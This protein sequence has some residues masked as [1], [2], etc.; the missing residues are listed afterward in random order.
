VQVEEAL[1]A[2]RGSAPAPTRHLRKHAA[3]AAAAE[4][5]AAASADGAAPGDA[6]A[7]SAAATPVRRAPPAG[8][9][10]DMWDLMEPEEILTKLGKREGDKPPFAKGAA[11]EKWK[12]R[13]AAFSD[14]R[15]AAGAL[16]L[17]PGGYAEAVGL[18]RRTV[19][20]DANIA[21]VGEAIDAATALA[22]GLRRDFRN[23]AKLLLPCFLDKLKD[24]TTNCIRAIHD[25]LNAFAA[26]CFS[27]L[28]VV[29]DVITVA[30][31]HKVAKV[32]IESMAWVTDCLRHLGKPSATRLHGSL[33]PVL[34]KLT[35]ASAP[36]VRDA[37]L[38]ALAALCA[39]SGGMSIGTIE[40]ATAG[41]EAARLKK[42]NE[43]VGKAGPTACLEADEPSRPQ[44]APPPESPGGAGGKARAGS[45]G[46]A[47]V[48]P[49]TPVGAA[50]AVAA[51]KP[52][53]AAAPAR[54][55][56]AAP[57]RAAYGAAAPVRA[58][59]A[60]A[61]PGVA[62]ARAAAAPTRA[63]PPAVAAPRLAATSRAAP[64]SASAAAAA[65]SRTAAYGAPSKLAATGPPA[66]ATGPR[67]GSGSRAPASANALRR[68]PGAPLASSA[69][70]TGSA[71]AP[72]AAA[73]A[74]ARAGSADGT[75]F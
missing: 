54:P 26:H 3:A 28:E 42:L 74:A 51:R 63:A 4:A 72:G 18:I 17:A 15:T 61:R 43:L 14:L 30:L 56:A 68:A 23:E 52:V 62:P 58:A 10:G 20:A 59:P 35:D 21:V 19:M 8:G 22:K 39:A 45:A 44:Y 75:R 36:A 65:T 73:A 9:A 40:K 32:Q 2:V 64:P 12:E 41:M 5:A 60:P 47:G 1:E 29:D 69:P 27:F 71:G 11:S 6:S 66:A 37:A 70:R 67:P 55:A 57:A 13:H 33:L 48:K 7:P 25:A 24:K 46:G 50:P 31:D 53:G 34:L 38:I 16:R 49:R